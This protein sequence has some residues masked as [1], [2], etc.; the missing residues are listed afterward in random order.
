MNGKQLREELILEMQTGIKNVIDGK[1]KEW[2][3]AFLCPDDVCGYLTS[4][5]FEE[6]PDIDTNGWEW[7]YWIH[8]E[9]DGKKWT[10][11]GCGYYGGISF[12]PKEEY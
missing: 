4:I 11:S 7:D 5:G 2:S 3:S 1:E 10:V 12:A 8:Y 6:H 9:Q